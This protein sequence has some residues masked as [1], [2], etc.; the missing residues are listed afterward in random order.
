MLMLLFVSLVSAK[1]STVTFTQDIRPGEAHSVS[2]SFAI[3]QKAWNSAASKVIAATCESPHTFAPIWTNARTLK[4]DITPA[5][6]PNEKCSFELPSV[7][8]VAPRAFEFRTARAKIISLNPWRF[9]DPGLFEDDPIELQVD[10]AINP[11][12]LAQH[13]HLEVQ[14]LEE[15]V[16]LAPVTPDVQASLAKTSYQAEGVQSYWF[17]FR[18]TLPTGK[19]IVLVI[20][21]DQTAAFKQEG[22]VRGPFVATARCLRTNP[23]SPCSPLG[24]VS[25]EFSAH[26]ANAD[27]S[28]A[29]LALGKKEYAPEANEEDSSS[30]NFKV[31]LPA[32]SAVEVRLPNNL[33]DVDGRELSNQS[34]F[35]LKMAIGEYPPLA[36]L[37]GSFGI[38]EAS[39][40][41][42]LPV[43]LRNTERPLK[44]R[45]NQTRWPSLSALNLM[46][47]MNAIDKRQYSHWE[48]DLRSTSV[49]AGTTHKL[50]TTELNPQLSQK[51]LE[52]IGLPLSGKGLHVVEV[53]S[54]KLGASLLGGTQ[55]LYVSS[56]VLVTNLAVHWKQ[57]ETNALAWVTSLDKGLPVANAK[58]TVSDCLGKM[59][60]SAVTGKDG[61]ALFPKLTKEN[62]KCVN[63]ELGLYGDTIVTAQT[64]DDFSFVNDKWQEGIES[65]RFDVARSY[66]NNFL[67][68]HTI[69]DRPLYQPGQTVSGVVL[70]RDFSDKGLV[71]PF[72]PMSKRLRFINTANEKSWDMTVAWNDLHAAPFKFQL[73]QESPLGMYG[74]YLLEKD[75]KGKDVVGK[76]VGYFDV[77]AFKVPLMSLRL[78]WENQK[79]Q[80]SNAKPSALV[81]SLHF[82]SGPPASEQKITVRGTLTPAYGTT[83]K[84]YEDFSFGTGEMRMLDESE[85]TVKIANNTLKT[86]K[87]GHFTY[88]P[89]KLP[90]KSYQQN[91]NLEVEYMDAS[92]LLQSQ[93]LH[94]KL[95]PANS[96]VG[97]KDPK[98]LD[99]KT[100]HTL[101]F[102]VVDLAGK[103][104]PKIAVKV[105]LYRRDWKSV[106]K[107]ILGGFYSYES[108]YQNEAMGEICQGRTNDQGLF[109]C[110]Y[111]FK[112]GGSFVFQASAQDDEGQTSKSFLQTHVRGTNDYSPEF[113]AH[114]RAD[115]VPNKKEYL[116]GD[117]ALLAFKIPFQESWVLVTKERRG[118]L[119]HSVVKLDQQNSALKLKITEADAPNQF[120]SALAVR[121]RVAAAAPAGNI[122]LGKPSVRVGLTEITVRRPETK[123]K[124]EVT[125]APQVVQVRQKLT[126]K[127][128]VSQF[129]GKALPKVK[130]A[131]AVIDAGLL[132]VRP[133]HSFNLDNAFAQNFTHGVD[134]ST[135]A[136]LIIGRRHFGL[137]AKPTGGDG[138]S[139]PTR[140][141]FDTLLYWDPAINVNAQ[142]EATITFPANDSLTEFKVMV[143]AYS[144]ALFGTGETSFKVTQDL[145]SFASLSP[146]LRTGDV[147]TANFT[148]QNTT[149]RPMGLEL[150]YQQFMGSNDALK[151][152]KVF[153]LPAGEAKV[154]SFANMKLSSPGSLTHNLAVKS[155]GKTLDK[156]VVAQKVLPLQTPMVMASDFYEVSKPV[157]VP[158]LNK[159]GNE[160][161]VQVYL[162]AGPLGSLE[163]LQQW[164]N[165]YAYNCLEQQTARLVILRTKP[166]LQKYLKELTL[167]QDSDGLFRYYPE[168]SLPGSATLT[169]HILEMFHWAGLEKMDALV[170]E[171]A[172]K[173]LMRVA[174]GEIG[175]N[176]FW[177]SKLT[178]ERIKLHSLATL[179]LIKSK[180]VKPQYAATYA[181]APATDTLADLVDKWIVFHATNRLA[182]RDTV[183]TELARRFEV[184]SAKLELKPRAEDQDFWLLATPVSQFA[185]FLLLAKQ[186]GLSPDLT[187]L[188]KGQEAKW[189]KGFAAQ[190]KAGHYGETVSNS[191]AALVHQHYVTKA[192]TGKTMVNSLVHPWPTNYAPLRITGDAMFAPLKLSH[193][194]SGVPYADV[195]YLAFLDPAKSFSKGFGVTKK[196]EF[197]EGQSPK[198]GERMRVSYTVTAQQ[199]STQVAMRL[200]LPSGVTALQVEVEGPSRPLYQER[201][202]DEV[203]LY[204]DQTQVGK[205][206][207]ITLVLRPNQ[208]GKFAYP[209]ARVEEMY[210]AQVFGKE[211]D[212]EMVIE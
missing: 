65:W 28:R 189:L 67:G 147:T 75:A 50:T 99:T 62:D 66:S 20:A 177:A 109:T 17:K 135:S 113:D 3:P 184:G 34:K 125:A 15:K 160:A 171:R 46:K 32:D 7:L 33:K 133:H 178:N 117:E 118:I 166:L 90:K 30:V 10:Q 186:I 173:A 198:I 45:F 149:D 12:Q 119:S 108:G 96:L 185:R 208:A 76:N 131:V 191:Y 192:P 146:T 19:K 183:L 13:A 29:R 162:S 159:Q 120:Y 107:K 168:T 179:S 104:R 128:K 154:V 210:A 98:N 58:V 126:A 40:E 201:D 199:N 150:D 80:F 145:L 41:V 53:E 163:S 134:T 174:A 49:F 5:L 151:E 127:I 63:K 211:P 59:V 25:L 124:V 73:P 164:I 122:D 181:P 6:V 123:L 22:Q 14:G 142:G 38:M 84:A 69:L 132:E 105:E 156:L 114:D 85:E 153:D 2:W 70:A 200:P 51:D 43:A 152:K 23:D 71:F 77:E 172:E 212:S 44:V 60:T 9:A 92:G 138:G 116:V 64:K 141:L 143:V 106:R 89:E 169:A 54:P 55:N 195:Q 61:V 121:G 72:K 167:H 111:R 39:P 170:R 175:L 187:T 103:A 180:H 112:Q 115:L 129:T 140:E 16:E 204:F 8:D 102:A 4:V 88:R 27:L 82:L 197:L 42:L 182:E 74:V 194:G 94:G 78:A 86:S 83:F 176:Y 193:Q 196:I 24:N 155:Q 139:R 11:A 203:R 165:D 93:F 87:T 57:G 101:S 137:K 48:K 190:R 205:A 47:W 202:F 1:T 188:F 37:P 21:E 144:E 100:A 110:S 209:G 95:N 81:G 79:N 161:F 35:P 26:V 56:L 158:A 148:L 97:I 130:L 52:M 91:L 31:P 206:Y 18:R 207:T 68:F 36:K 136:G 157:E